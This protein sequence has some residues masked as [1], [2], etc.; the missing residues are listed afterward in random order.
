M[1]KTIYNYAESLDEESSKQ[2]K[3]KLCL[4]DI[5][6]NYIEERLTLQMEHLFCVSGGKK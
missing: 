5:A 1:N 4:I 6:V 3:E 2:Y